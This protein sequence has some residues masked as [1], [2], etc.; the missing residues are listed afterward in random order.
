MKIELPYMFNDCLST[1]PKE[2][3]DNFIVIY[4]K[5]MLGDIVF[6]DGY[7]EAAAILVE[8]FKESVPRAG[9]DILAT[10][11]LNIYA[12]VLEFWLKFCIRKIDSHIQR[13]KCRDFNVV[14]EK[15][16]VLETHNLKDL[17]DLLGEMLVEETALHVVSNFDQVKKFIHDFHDFGIQSYSTRYLNEKKG[18]MY[19]LYSKQSWL[20]IHEMHESIVSI[21][22]S[23]EYIFYGTHFEYCDAGLL[24]NRALKELKFC[25]KTAE[26]NLADI[27]NYNKEKLKNNNSHNQLAAIVKSLYLASRGLKSVEDLDYFI[28]WNEDQLFNKIEERKG[29]SVVVLERMD[30]H[31]QTLDDYIKCKRK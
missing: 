26:D 23:F 29:Y 20:Y 14:T 16:G 27:E 4:K 22:K 28:E 9:D 3:D 19:P 8:K 31:I 1:R 21:I 25:K 30:S 18:G 6:I 5:N 17:V 15:M 24:T 13:V 12:N 10:P 7:M 11:L 2:I